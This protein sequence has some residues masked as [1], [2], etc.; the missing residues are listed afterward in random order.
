MTRLS[1]SRTSTALRSLL[2][3]NRTMRSS[4]DTSIGL[5]LIEF[6]DQLATMKTTTRSSFPSSFSYSMWQ[7]S[8]DFSNDERTSHPLW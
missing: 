4:S 8:K 6:A 1:P 5:P 3:I 2:D 7:P